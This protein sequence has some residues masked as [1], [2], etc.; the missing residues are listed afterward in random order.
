MG[1]SIDFCILTAAQ[2]GVNTFLRKLLCG[3]Y[4]G[5]FYTFACS[6]VNFRGTGRPPWA[7]S[8]AV[9]QA[10]FFFVVMR[11]L[12]V[13][14]ELARG[15]RVRL[16]VEVSFAIVTAASGG[17]PGAALADVGKGLVEPSLGLFVGKVDFVRHGESL[18]MRVAGVLNRMYST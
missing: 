5:V 16:R 6:T 4:S 3:P 2:V 17:Q 8:A 1:W 14:E 13:T 12:A 10:L 15:V 9:A 18:V 11:A 7:T